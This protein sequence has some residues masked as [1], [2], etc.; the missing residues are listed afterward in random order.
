MKQTIF[1]LRWQFREASPVPKARNVVVFWE[2]SV[3]ASVFHI[4]NNYGAEWFLGGRWMC[5]VQRPFF[6]ICTSVLGVRSLTLVSSFGE[7]AAV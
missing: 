5:Q 6:L 1:V 7:A 3:I 4:L 2:P